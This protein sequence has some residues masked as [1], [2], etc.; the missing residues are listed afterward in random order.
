VIADIAV[1]GIFVPHAGHWQVLVEAMFNAQNRRAIK[2]FAMSTEAPDGG[3]LFLFP[4]VKLN[5]VRLG[6]GK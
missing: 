5:P 4:R 6:E 2:P 3:D 1:I